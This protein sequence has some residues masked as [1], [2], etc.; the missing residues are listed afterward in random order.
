MPIDDPRLQLRT[1]L[2]RKERWLIPWWFSWPYKQCVVCGRRFW[3]SWPWCIFEECCSKKC[4]D[5][6]LEEICGEGEN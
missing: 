6:L 2:G 1:I 3:R 5:E 4:N